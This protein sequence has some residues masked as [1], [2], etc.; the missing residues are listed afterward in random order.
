MRDNF[1][2]KGEVY[3]TELSGIYEDLT[4][5][6]PSNDVYVASETFIRNCHIILFDDSGLRFTG[7]SCYLLDNYFESRSKVSILIQNEFR[8]YPE[9]VYNTF[10]VLRSHRDKYIFNN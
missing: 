6:L 4:L 7:D 3:V 2:T 8:I 9:T 5:I 1:G 10:W